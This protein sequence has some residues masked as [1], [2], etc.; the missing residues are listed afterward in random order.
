[1]L[2]SLWGQ[3]NSRWTLC[4]EII[5]SLDTALMTFLSLFHEHLENRSK[6]DSI[7]EAKDGVGKCEYV[8]PETALGHLYSIVLLVLTQGFS[9]IKL[10][11]ILGDITRVLP[12]TGIIVVSLFALS[13]MNLSRISMITKSHPSFVYPIWKKER[14]T[15]VAGEL[16]CSWCEKVSYL[17]REMHLLVMLIV[18]VHF[19]IWKDV[20]SWEL[21]HFCYWNKDVKLPTYSENSWDLSICNLYR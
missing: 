18:K 6:Y 2:I 17:I 9:R 21:R 13:K 8:S 20:T 10:G 19:E 5:L 1:M 14:H 4:L 11:Y 3:I 15:H 12:H 7:N 16:H